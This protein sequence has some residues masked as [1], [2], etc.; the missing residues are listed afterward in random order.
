MQLFFFKCRPG[1]WCLHQRPVRRARCR[2]WIEALLGALRL[3]KPF[4]TAAVCRLAQ[5]TGWQRI[6]IVD[7]LWYEAALGCVI[8]AVAQVIWQLSC[9]AAIYMDQMSGFIRSLVTLLRALG[10]YSHRW[11]NNCCPSCQMPREKQLINYSSLTSGVIF[12]IILVLQG[13]NNLGSQLLFPPVWILIEVKWLFVVFLL[14][15]Q[16]CF[17]AV[18]CPS[19]ND[20]ALICGCFLLKLT[21]LLCTVVWEQDE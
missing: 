9:L 2:N 20:A 4:K 7:I 19:S 11:E 17:T 15:R 10:F 5:L 1:P 14:H 13:L 12:S 8:A 21:H 6:V 16:V 3:V 18:D